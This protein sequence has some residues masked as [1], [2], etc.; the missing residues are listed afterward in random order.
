MPRAQEC[1]GLAPL[2][3]LSAYMPG[4]TYLRKVIAEKDVDKQMR[5]MVLRL[6]LAHTTKLFFFRT[7]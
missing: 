7:S 2:L 3:K 6:L 1:L 5:I 4:G